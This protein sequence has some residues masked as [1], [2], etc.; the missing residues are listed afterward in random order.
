MP[1]TEPYWLA[2]PQKDDAH[3]AIPQQEYLGLPLTPNP[4][5]ATTRVQVADETF[6]VEIPLS[7]KTLDATHGDVV[8]PLGV[9]PEVT[10]AFADDKVTLLADGSVRADVQV[11]TS[12]RLP[13]AK[14]IIYAGS[15]TDTVQMAD[16]M[17]G[18]M[19]VPASVPA[20]KLDFSEGK[21]EVKVA[22]LSDGKLYNKQRR[23]IK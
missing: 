5:V 18:V 1:Y 2:E 8:E 16:V 14:M 17:P 11:T 10:L 19:I 12:A 4:L 15:Y 6:L 20:G 7:Y 9:A 21:A 3:Y 23:V 22:V 13:M